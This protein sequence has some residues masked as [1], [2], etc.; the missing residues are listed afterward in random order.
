MLLSG[1][2]NMATGQA[3]ACPPPDSASVRE[4][5]AQSEPSA[6]FGPAHSGVDSISDRPHF[7]DPHLVEASIGA[8]RVLLMLAYRPSAVGIVDSLFV[9]FHSPSRIEAQRLRR[10]YHLTKQPVLAG[11]GWGSYV[12]RTYPSTPGTPRQLLGSLAGDGSID[13]NVER[14]NGSNCQDCGGFTIVRME[15]WG[16]TGWWSADGAVTPESLGWFCAFTLATKP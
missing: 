2:A 4:W 9:S 8:F 12:E 10:A 6:E 13:F 5:P 3:T 15:P 7:R 14:E 16:L 11:Y 1:A